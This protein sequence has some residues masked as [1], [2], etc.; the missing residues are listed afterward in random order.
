VAVILVMGAITIM[1]IMLS[2]MQDETASDLSSALSERDALK[3]EYAARS[4]INLSRLLIAAEPT[5][6]RTLTP[7]FMMMRQSP[8]QIPVW[9]FADQVLGAFGDSEGVDR[10]KGLT[11]VDMT[12]AKNLGLAGAGFEI[13]VVDEDSKLN[14]NL[15]ARADAFSQGRAGAAILGLIEGQQYNS[16]FE[17]RDADGQFSTRQ[18]VCSAIVDWADPNTEGFGCEPHAE[19]ATAYG[20]EDSFYQML[21]SP[22]PRKNAAFD[23]LEE[24]RLVRGMGD[25]FWATFVDP[26]PDDPRSRPV[27]IWGQGAT[28]VNTAN[29]Q[30]I[31]AIVCANALEAAI[32]TDPEQAIQFL[33]TV[34]LIRSF[35][36]GAP[37]FGSPK[38]F[39]NAMQGRGSVGQVLAAIGV[40]PATFRSE[41]EALKTIA[42]ESKV[43]SIVATGYVKQG[44]RETRVRVHSV[45]DFR[46]APAP[47]EAILDAVTALTGGGGAPSTATG[48]KSGKGQSELPEGVTEEGIAGAFRADPAGKVLYYR[49]N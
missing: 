37:M 31:L 1:A 36:A 19:T 48:D 28:N 5:I 39:L 22:Y 44:K 2:E 38:A 24:L 3:A 12:Q 26:N 14:F 33:S 20:P 30:A 46:G 11:P 25:D 17:E 47:T 49:I 10:F 43:F 16:L 40:Q 45:V 21:P 4:A 34:E 32:C 13:V 15:A 27:T 29:A 35:T 9:E 41:S 42:T 23:S 6:R 8:P 7:L 18:D